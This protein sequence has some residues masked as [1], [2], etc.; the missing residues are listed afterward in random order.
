MIV[1]TLFDYFKEARE[2]DWITYKILANIELPFSNRFSLFVFSNPQRLSFDGIGGV[3]SAEDIQK[4]IESTT[5]GETSFWETTK[6][7]AS[8]V[9]SAIVD[10]GVPFLYGALND[11]L[12]SQK[13]AELIEDSYSKIPTYKL[14]SLLE[15]NIPATTDP[16]LLWWFNE[17][18]KKPYQ[19][20]WQWKAKTL[21]GAFFGLNLLGLGTILKDVIV[22]RVFL[23]SISIPFPFNI[24]YERQGSK[25]Y[26]KNVTYNYDF[27][28]EFYDNSDGLVYRYFMDWFLT[29][30]EP[31]SIID[32]RG[33]LVYDDIEFAKK[34]AILFIKQENNKY[35]YPAFL[36]SGIMPK[37]INEISLDHSSSEPLF[38][39]AEFTCDWIFPIDFVLDLLANSD[40]SKAGVSNFF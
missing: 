31:R 7:I 6:S 38:V 4:K 24:E 5:K 26:I 23:K 37:S 17:K 28:A 2:I 14:T 25:S 22:S 39:K 13:L 9:G 3:L 36:I 20:T 8:S 10:Y 34:S 29:I 35:K 12:Q 16:F 32:K 40:I 21:T 11:F 19:E 27:S 15:S 18:V 1:Q 30:V 33:M